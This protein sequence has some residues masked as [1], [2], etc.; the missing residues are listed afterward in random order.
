M[1]SPPTA[2]NAFTVTQAYEDVSD[3][4]PES[5]P[6]DVVCVAPGT[7]MHLLSS[8]EF[9]M[10]SITA[11]HLDGTGPHVPYPPRLALL[12]FNAYGVCEGED[13]VCL[14]WQRGGSFERG[15]TESGP[16]TIGERGGQEVERRQRVR[17]SPSLHFEEYNGPLRPM[18]NNHTGRESH[19]SSSGLQVGPYTLRIVDESGGSGLCV[20][21]CDARVPGQKGQGGVKS[22]WPLVRSDGRDMQCDL[23]GVPDS[24]LLWDVDT[25][26]VRALTR[27]GRVRVSKISIPPSVMLE[28]LG[29]LRQ[30][31]RQLNTAP[32][33]VAFRLCRALSLTPMSAQALSVVTETLTGIER[34][35]GLCG[36]GASVPGEDWD[37]CEGLLRQWAHI[38]SRD[39]TVAAICVG[40]TG[41]VSQITEVYEHDWSCHV[42]S[43]VLAC[44]DKRTIPVPSI[45]AVNTICEVASE[46]YPGRPISSFSIDV[47]QEYL[48]VVITAAARAPLSIPLWRA[49]ARG[50][51]SRLSHSPACVLDLTHLSLDTKGKGM[52]FLLSLLHSVSFSALTGSRLQ[53]LLPPS[54]PRPLACIIR[55]ALLSDEQCKEEHVACASF[56]DPNGF[57]PLVSGAIYTPYRMYMAVPGKLV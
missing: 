43:L 29:Y 34:V 38:V 20:C 19:Y 14:E 51:V 48:S 35:A 46:I 4:P 53:V 5:L 7:I 55:A 13:L 8:V 25:L 24:L 50:L 32:S 10:T 27:S 44:S 11:L 40:T 22:K 2:D 17:M 31:A 15:Q 26:F 30:T 52:A 6:L 28:M 23:S 9:P 41:D 33:N 54:L 18:V 49:L 42:A 3:M 16:S 39:A 57:H 12:P 56:Y 36:L 47:P 1:P 37:E 45:A 21:M